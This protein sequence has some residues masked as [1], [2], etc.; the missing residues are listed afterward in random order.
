MPRPGALYFLNLYLE[1]IRTTVFRQMLFAEFE[2]L[3]HAAVEK[4]EVLTADKLEGIWMKL[5]R[6]YYGQDV[7]LDP[8]LAAE[9]SRIPHFYRPF[10]V[11]QYATGYAAAMTL[12]HNLRTKGEPAR[13][14]YLA[15]S[16]AAAATTPSSCSSG[17]RRHDE[18]GAFRLTFEK[19]RQCLDELAASCPQ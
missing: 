4:G 1:Q 13:K 5:N 16:R 11:Y 2:L 12:S 8:G 7:A 3:T 17:P 10:Y 15:T 18:Y 19:F 6:T 9:W 14:A